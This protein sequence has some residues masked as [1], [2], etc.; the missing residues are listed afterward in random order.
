MKATVSFYTFGCRL[1][2]AETAILQRSF[3]KQ[4]YKVVD[5]QA[6]SDV[7]VVNT[8]TVTENGDADTRKLVNKINRRH[9]RAR[10]AL[11]GCQAQIQREKLLNLPNVRWVVGNAR[12]MDF[13][14][15]L[16]NHLQDEKSRVI[17][18]VISRKSFRLPLA[19]ID[20]EHTRAN[21]KIQ[22]GC[23][24][25]CSFCVIPY[26]RGRA[27]S[28]EFSDI[29]SEAEMMVQAGHREI[30]LT[31]INIGTYQYWGKDLPEVVDELEKLEG[32]D[33]LRISSIEPTTIAHQLVEKMRP[34]S[35]L[36]RYLHIPLQS[37]SNEI[38]FAMNR[39]YSR[40][41]F[42]DFIR[43]VQSSVPGVC[44]GTDVIVGFPGEKEEHFRQ[45]Y[46][47]LLELP[48][49]Y[50][51]VFSYSERPW[52]RSRKFKSQVPAEVVEE[53]SRVLRELSS[54]KR[55][56]YLHENIG[57]VQMVLFEQKKKE[58]WRGLTDTYIRVLV[59]SERDLRNQLVP[60]RLK[61]VSGNMVLG[62]LTESG[63]AGN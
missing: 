48:L 24:F 51:H 57:S 1:N 45:T 12:K 22:D 20:R 26:A 8:C 25:F 15:I 58:K 54:R 13:A 30:V 27:R 55:T 63:L 19:G 37:G 35:K 23:D 33:R 29:I 52:A 42:E 2:Q 40:Q 61:K 53:R 49:T 10:I 47:F 62:D 14:G 38:L 50:F 18:P 46:E 39:R 34:E 3:E 59:E 9:P 41:E 21:L 60:V 6:P 56:I 7:V 28:R 5:F 17:T 44:I 32:L 11:L 36:C 43:F 4:G 31:G 16:D